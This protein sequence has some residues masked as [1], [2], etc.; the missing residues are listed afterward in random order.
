MKKVVFF[1]AA[2][3]LCL[4]GTNEVQ[5]QKQI[6][7][8]KNVEFQFSPLGGNPI[9]INGIRLRLFNSES[10]AIRVNVFVGSSTDKTVNTE[11]GAIS[12]EDP[13]SPILFDYARMF[14]LTIRPGYEMHFDGTDRLSPYVG[15]EIDFG[16]GNVSSESEFWGPNDIDDAGELEQY[17]VWTETQKQSYTRFG[18]NLLCG[19]DFYFADNVYLGAEMGFGFS[20]TSWADEELEVSDQVA[21]NLLN[22]NDSDEDLP[23][24]GA[25]DLS[26]QSNSF[27]VG[28]NVN[29][30][31]RLGFLIN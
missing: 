13:V 30:Q 4:A 31:I 25:G 17:I 19:F 5:A 21:Y 29:G 28:P 15:A 26:D 10:S 1:I 23:A 18:L 7:G 11:E 24:A 27:A 8:D 6:G 3:L 20:N 2:A 16:I 22:G 12:T 9:G 14:D